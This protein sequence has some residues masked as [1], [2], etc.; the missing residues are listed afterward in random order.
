MK[1]KIATI[2]VPVALAAALAAC[3]PPIEHEDMNPDD[4]AAVEAT[5]NQARIF[6]TAA[7]DPQHRRPRNGRMDQPEVD[8]AL[9]A[10]AETGQRRPVILYLHGC[11]GHVYGVG[12]LAR[13][14]AGKGYITIAPASFARPGRREQC[15]TTSANPQSPIIVTRE[16]EIRYA[17][18]QLERAP[19]VKQT[20]VYLMGQSEGGVAV[21]WSRAESFRARVVLAV[22]CTDPHYATV[23]GPPT[24]PALALVGRKDVEHI[25]R[26]G[27]VR[28]CKT[29]AHPLS[30]SR[31]LE[32]SVHLLTLH[33]PA[34]VAIERFLRA[35]D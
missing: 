22:S 12:P 27:A 30:D 14:L 25:R 10:L 8:E 29:N 6:Y 24:Q 3:V 17:R 28:K 34:H 1:P 33:P 21:A 11:T 4:Q 9:Q 15:T 2:M 20:H 23:R 35:T 19:W 7:D 13:R 18:T 16:Q 5:W 32:T 26:R 31:F